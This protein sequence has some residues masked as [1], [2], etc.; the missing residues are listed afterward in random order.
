MHS[1]GNAKRHTPISINTN[2][3]QNKLTR[4]NANRKNKTNKKTDTRKHAHKHV[5]THNLK[6]ALMEAHKH[7]QRNK[8]TDS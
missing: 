5:N 6:D 3:H 7:L 2:L 4:S 1:D 8:Q